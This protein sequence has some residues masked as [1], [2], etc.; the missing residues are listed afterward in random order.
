[1]SEHSESK[2]SMYPS[3][4]DRDGL[5]GADKSRGGGNPYDAEQG[6]NPFSIP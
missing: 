2:A 3:G 5:G 4:A 1:M 6:G